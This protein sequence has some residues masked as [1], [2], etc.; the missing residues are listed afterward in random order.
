[1]AVFCLAMLT[2]CSIAGS[3]KTVRIDPS[4]MADSFAF[5]SV[6]FD[7]DGKY[8]AVVKYGG[9]S[10]TNSGKYE[11][12]GFTLTITPREGDE[13]EYRGE[14]WWGKTLKLHHKHDGKSMTGVLE[15][16]AE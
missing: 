11:W 12:D 15:R 10:Q 16:V 4:D 2:G 1:M 6:D 13:R 5:S 9:K 8:S 7:K 14:L 3:W